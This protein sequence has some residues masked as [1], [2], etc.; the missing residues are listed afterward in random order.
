MISILNKLKNYNQ[1]F[2]FKKNFFL[3]FSWTLIWLH[4]NSKINYSKLSF[5][6]STEYFIDLI[7]FTRYW[8]IFLIPFFFLVIFRLKSFKINTPII[9]LFAF[10]FLQI[11]A[12]GNFKYVNSDIYN[13]L[14]L[15]NDLIKNGY[16]IRFSYS[17]FTA[18]SFSI[19]LFVISICQ[20]SKEI[21]KNLFKIS[22]VILGIITIIY[23]LK[24][25]YEFINSDKENLYYLPFLTWGIWGGIPSPRA[26]GMARWFLILFIFFISCLFFENNKIK[27][28]IYFSF[29]IF[30]GIFIILLQS[31]TSFYLM[32]LFSIF[33]IFIDKERFKNFKVLLIII[34]LQFSFSKIFYEVKEIYFLKTKNIEKTELEKISENYYKDKNRQKFRVLSANDNITTGRTVI[35]KNILKISFSKPLT[36]QL[37]GFGSQADRYLVQQN[38]SNAILYVLI[39]SGFIG[40]AIF[41]FIFLI[42]LKSI[43]YFF[44][45]SES[46]KK[47]DKYY[48]FSIFILIFLTL[49]SIVEN[50]FTVFG[51]DYIFFLK[52]YFYI[53]NS[54][55]HDEKKL[56]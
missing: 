40:L 16:N 19:P 8:I 12:Y 44:K 35:W 27:K 18:L 51:I 1:T 45:D 20:T 55:L 30:C 49:R 21:L 17:F 52:A 41:L 37:I 56:S 32:L 25:T 34:I 39:C 26:T 36:N 4:L 7:N 47:V 15:S 54:S 43:I 10:S 38:A 3:Y 2:S 9:L 48:L 28:N 46:Y 24:I 13:E 29:I 5:E 11:I 31:R 42:I 14:L 22:L 6:L 50:S 23:T 33:L 53:L